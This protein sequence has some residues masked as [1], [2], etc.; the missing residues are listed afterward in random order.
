[1]DNG[2]P[3]LVWIVL[4]NQKTEPMIYVVS[5]KTVGDA[6]AAGGEL[7]RADETVVDHDSGIGDVHVHRAKTSVGKWAE[8]T[9]TAE[10][11]FR[12]LPVPETETEMAPYGT[13]NGVPITEEMIRR[14]AV[15]AEE[16]LDPDRLVPRKG[17]TER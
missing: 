8:T 12:E 7:W 10:A 3:E 11:T 2:M 15:K 16:G 14:A 13:R 1:M 9:E 4:I 17:A 6:A 5:A